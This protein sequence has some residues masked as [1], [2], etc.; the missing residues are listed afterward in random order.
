[1]NPE[2]ENSLYFTK[3]AERGEGSSFPNV[4]GRSETKNRKQG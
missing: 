4:S 2:D 1:M 3:A